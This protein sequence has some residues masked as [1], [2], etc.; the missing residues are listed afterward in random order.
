MNTNLMRKAIPNLTSSK[1]FV[2]A[3]AHNERPLATD[4]EA[5]DFQR[6]GLNQLKPDGAMNEQQSQFAAPPIRG[7]VSFS[8]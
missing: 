4:E 5:H 2:G 7:R 6:S 3:L 1:Q 8:V